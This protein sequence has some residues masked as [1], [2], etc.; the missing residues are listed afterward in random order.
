MGH[1]LRS[2]APAGHGARGWLP[3]PPLCRRTLPEAGSGFLAGYKQCS[4]GWGRVGAA[5]GAQAAVSREGWGEQGTHSKGQEE[6][7]SIT[8]PHRLLPWR[9]GMPGRAWL[10]VPSPPPP[11]L[12]T[13]W[14][15]RRTTA[16]L[17]RDGKGRGLDSPV[18]CVWAIAGN[19]QGGDLSK[20]P[21]A[22]RAACRLPGA[23]REGAV[24]MA[25]P[26]GHV[27]CRATKG[28]SPPCAAKGSTRPQQWVHGETGERG[29]KLGCGEQRALGQAGGGPG[30]AGRWDAGPW[31]RTCGRSSRAACLLLQGQPLRAAPGTQLHFPAPGSRP[32]T[33]RRGRV[34]WLVPFSRSIAKGGSAVAPSP[35]S[36]CRALE[37][38]GPLGPEGTRSGSFTSDLQLGLALLGAVLIDSLAG[39]EAGVG[40]LRRQD[41]QREEPP[42]RLRLLRV[43]PAAVLHRLPVPQPAR[44]M[45]RATWSCLALHAQPGCVQTIPLLHPQP[46]SGPELQAGHPQM[47]RSPCLSP[48]S[49][50]SC[51]PAS[52]GTH[53]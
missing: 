14:G 15:P 12:H 28:K 30:T 46:C 44:D 41:V 45:D 21:C 24:G 20:L 16:G 35:H 49:L 50:P 25:G 43:V 1:R 53:Q 4:Q 7:G 51:D 34:G 10:S 11:H 40:A 48:P 18:P 6:G 9:R 3:L 32:R 52:T 23:G 39:V 19:G 42:R 29:V 5:Q 33:L 36:S 31:G 17:G 47:G 27:P 26:G 8:R 22:W 13:Y 2:P 38:A 37:P